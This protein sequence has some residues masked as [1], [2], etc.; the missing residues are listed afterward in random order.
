MELDVVAQL[1]ALSARTAPKARG[2]DFIEVKLLSVEERERLG[3]AMIEEGER[4]SG[5]FIRDGKNVMDSDGL[6]LIGLK[7]HRSGGTNC[8]GCGFGDCKSFDDREKTD[9]AYRGP[10]C[11]LRLIDLGIAVGSA[12]K[13]ASLLNADNRVMFRAGAIAR[14]EG[15]MESDVVIGIPISATGKSI[16][17][18]R[19]R[20]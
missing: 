6:V 3:R 12:V 7:E 14:R 18:D 8:N 16:Y 1:M 2:E 13:M 5:N 10:N 19:G 17:F 15:M 11:T 9:G 20:D 4:G